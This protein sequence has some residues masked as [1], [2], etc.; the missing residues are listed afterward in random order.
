M[1]ADPLSVGKLPAAV[2]VLEVPIVGKGAPAVAWDMFTDGRLPP[3]AVLDAV[4]AEKLLLVMAA[5]GVGSGPRDPML[6]TAGEAL[7]RMP[8]IE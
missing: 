8:C 1:A 2:A 3:A 4:S 5:A 7:G 6:M